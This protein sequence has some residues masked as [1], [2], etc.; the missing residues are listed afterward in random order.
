MLDYKSIATWQDYSYHF[1]SALQKLPSIQRD[2]FRG[3]DLRL[4]QM[5][6]LYQEDGL[7]GNL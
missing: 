5:S 2:V 6:H 7:V 1:I 3:L 4:T